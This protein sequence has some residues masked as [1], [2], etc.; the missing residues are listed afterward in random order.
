MA[1]TNFH[2]HCFYCD[3]KDSPEAYVL[4][5][6]EL[7][8]PCYGFS[9]NSPVPFKSVWNMKARNVNKYIEHIRKLKEKYKS[10]IQL[11]CSM[12]VDFVPDLMGPK[13]KIITDLKLDYTIGSIHYLDAF[14]NGQ[15]W[16]IDGTHEVF[17]NGLQEIFHGD[18]KKAVQR[19]YELT[20]TMV[21]TEQPDVIGHL[22]KI[23]IQ[24]ES[25]TLFSEQDD[26]YRLEVLKTLDLIAK[27]S[28]IIE[29][30]TRG[31]YQNKT[32]EPY[33]SWWILKEIYN[34]NIPIMLNS[35]A[36]DPNEIISEFSKIAL[37]LKQIGF[38]KLK[39]LYNYKWIDVAFSE[40]GILLN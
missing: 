36:H 22:D 8:M 16:E 9:S 32:T 23:K 25:G 19:F 27:S 10:Q 39:I 37:Q 3:G 5:A 14:R 40:H 24:S 30:N 2:G 6:I 35:D 7:Q 28:S 21:E 34:R 12:E 20:R 4:K 17:K 31:I 29:V 11:Y 33:P 38:Q 13:N 15:P 26:W 18:V 1:W